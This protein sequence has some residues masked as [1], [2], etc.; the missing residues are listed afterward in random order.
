MRYPELADIL[1]YDRCD[2]Q[3]KGT[4]SGR[5]EAN[6]FDCE[7][8]IAKPNRIDCL[9]SMGPGQIMLVPVPSPLIP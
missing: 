9:T 4:L 8:D 7:E 1:D 3:E 2:V 5:A 6:E